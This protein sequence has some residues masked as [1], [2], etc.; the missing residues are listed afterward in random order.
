M[1]KNYHPLNTIPSAEWIYVFGA[2][3]GGKH[4]KGAAKIARVNFRA[5]YGRDSGRT[6]QA[7]AICT[8]AKNSAK[9]E[10]TGLQTAIEG[11]ITYAN[12]HPELKFFISQIGHDDGYAPAEIAPYFKN[13]PMNCSLPQSWQTVH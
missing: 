11:F 8:K 1:S 9:I 5:E 10:A 6:N 12:A 13:A 4:N 7:Y 2:S 3:A